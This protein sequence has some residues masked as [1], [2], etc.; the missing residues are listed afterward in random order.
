MRAG[1][2]SFGGYL[3]VRILK[4][5]SALAIGAVLFLVVVLFLLNHLIEAGE[6]RDLLIRELEGRT[7]LKVGVGAVEMD[8]G[9][10]TGIV[11]KDFSLSDPLTSL[12]I[13]TAPRMV[14]RVA[15]LPL[16]NWQIVLQDISFHQP[17]LQVIRNQEGKVDVLEILGRI[18]FQKPEDFPFT[19]DL[20]EIRMESAQVIFH[21]QFHRPDRLTTELREADLSLRRVGRNG[22]LDVSTGQNEKNQLVNDE[23]PAVDYRLKTVVE[24]EGQRAEI[25]SQGRI[26]FVGDS[27]ELRHARVEADLQAEKWPSG[28]LQEYYRD[29][30]PWREWSGTFNANF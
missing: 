25:A 30:L 15:L 19:L 8:L 2:L 17:T 22:L 4:L 6:F 14:T 5:A 9:G 16:W 27:F 3:L 1:G 13:L 23:K 28:L 10:I 7:R 11:L 26:T 29:Y 18:L 20:N 21:D 12:S 24:R